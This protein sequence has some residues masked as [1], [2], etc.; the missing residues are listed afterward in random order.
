MQENQY[1]R[2]QYQ[3]DYDTIKGYVFSAFF[4]GVVGLLIG[5][6]V[7][8]Q[9]WA[10]SLNFEPYFTFGRLRVVHVNILAYGLGICLEFGLF[11]YMVVRLAKRPL[12]LP[13]LARIKLYIFNAAMVVALITLLMGYTQSNEY[14]EFEWPLDL[15]VTLL[16]V[17]FAINVLGTIMLRKDSQMYISLWYMI[18]TIIAVA[19]LYIVNNLSIPVGLFKSYHLFNGGNSANVE[20]W[21]GHNAVGFLFTTPIL[22]MVYYFLP[23][24]LG[25]PVYSHRLSIISFWSLIFLYLW[26]GAHHLVYTPM[27]TWLQ[28]AAIALSMMLIIPSWGSVVNIYMTISADWSKLTSNPLAKFFLL[29]ITFYGLQTVQGPTQSLRE[30]SAIVHYTDYIPGHVHMGTM[31]WVAMALAGCIYYMFPRLYGMNEMKSIPM[32]N[33]HFWLVLIGQL[34]FSISLWVSGL[35]QGVMLQQYNQDGQLK[36]TFLDTLIT[37]MPYHVIASIGG[38]IFILGMV[39]FLLNVILTAIEGKNRQLSSARA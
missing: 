8:V 4:W 9:Y 11:Y 10:P 6:L 27:P 34:M 18:A 37:T 12:L 22:A 33:I 1:S 5:L 36:Y 23:K 29:A 15:G 14:A 26:T 16:W 28:T 19:M 3:Y 25:L 35:Q 21:Y 39:V 31:G 20:W 32:I 7:S 13:K 17:F 24:S 30:L 38:L 2:E